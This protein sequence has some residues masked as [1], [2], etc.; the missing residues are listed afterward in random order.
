[1]LNKLLCFLGVVLVVLVA[2]GAIFEF[3]KR[4]NKFCGLEDYDDIIE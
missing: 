3:T 4:K 1:M 2:V